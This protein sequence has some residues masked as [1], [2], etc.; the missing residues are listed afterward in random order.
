MNE[1]QEE[2]R[3]LNKAEYRAWLEAHREEFRVANEIDRLLYDGY[4]ITPG[5]GFIVWNSVA[6]Y[7]SL[8]NLRPEALDVAKKVRRILDALPS[9]DKRD[10]VENIVEASA[11]TAL[12]MNARAPS[13]DAIVETAAPA[14][15]RRA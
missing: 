9:D 7:G 15:G 5:E 4:P 8:G 10:F 13:F 12:G 11:Y 1:N 3:E 2:L 14:G 6:R